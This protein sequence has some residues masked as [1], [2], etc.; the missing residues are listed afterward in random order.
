MFE[1]ILSTIAAE[2]KSVNKRSFIL[3]QQQ[4]VCTHLHLPERLLLFVV[5]RNYGNII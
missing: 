1:T 5:M 2:K 3:R 4:K